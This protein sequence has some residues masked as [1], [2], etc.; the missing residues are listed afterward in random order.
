MASNSAER[1]EGGD[2]AGLAPAFAF[3]AHDTARPSGGWSSCA[4]RRSVQ[5]DFAGGPHQL[6]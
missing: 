6:G 5:L 3:P 2:V 1:A 4:P